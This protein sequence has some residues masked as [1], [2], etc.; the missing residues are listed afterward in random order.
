LFKLI[1]NKIFLFFIAATLYEK[2]KI[3]FSNSDP[4]LKKKFLLIFSLLPLFLEGEGAKK[5]F[6]FF[7]IKAKSIKNYNFLNILREIFILCL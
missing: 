3:F 2:K 7:K 6:K 5:F 1:K 4:A